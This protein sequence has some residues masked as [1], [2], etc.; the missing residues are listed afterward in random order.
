MNSDKKEV[1]Q[2]DV[3][4][5]DPDTSYNQ[6]YSYIGCDG[7]H[8][9]SRVQRGKRPWM[10]VSNN[11]GNLT[12]TTCNVVPITLESKPAY[13]PAHTCYKYNGK[14]QTVLC[15]QI[16]TIDTNALGNYIYTVSDETKSNVLKTLRIQFGM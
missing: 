12:S 16:R 9:N 15:E 10:V 3:F 8:Y 14:R 6:A 5:F 2:G 13:I 4:W 7:K 1:Q 11:M